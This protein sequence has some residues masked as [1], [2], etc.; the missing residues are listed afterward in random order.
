MTVPRVMI[1]TGHGLNCEQETAQAF[2]LAGAQVRLLHL[3]D[4]FADPSVLS[5]FHVLAFVGGFSYGDHIA[6]GTVL[7][8]QFLTHARDSLEEFIGDGK[9]VLGICNG[10][11]ALVKMGLLPGLH[12]D[13]FTQTATLMANDSG[14]FEDR[15]V[16][17]KSNPDSPCIFTKSLDF[18][19]L[20]VRHGEG[21]LF[22][23]DPVLDLLAAE[24]LIPLVYVNPDGTP[25]TTYPRNPN[26][27]LLSA[28]GLCDPT[29]HIFGLIPHPEASLTS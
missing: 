23:E 29:G 4:F 8:T 26:G 11:Q 12:G 17:L 15:W 9:L 24:H 2:S 7:A 10:F 1:L 19:E 13:Y 14:K 5:E 3:N 27:S 28:A 22:A 16:S 18:L 20:P 21:K 6:A 25:A